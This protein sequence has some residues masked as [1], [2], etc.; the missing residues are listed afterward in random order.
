MF[1]GI[2]VALPN[3][4]GTDND[5]YSYVSDVGI[6]YSMFINDGIV[7]SSAEFSNTFKG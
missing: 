6:I 3:L 2:V 5:L 1:T 7:Y 4:Y